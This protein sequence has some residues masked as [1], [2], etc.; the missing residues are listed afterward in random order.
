MKIY[1]IAAHRQ[2]WDEHMIPCS[3][4]NQYDCECGLTRD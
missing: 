1:E 3:G 4:C 2:G